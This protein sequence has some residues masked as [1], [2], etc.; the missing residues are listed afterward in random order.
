MMTSIF[1][2][3]CWLLRVLSRTNR[4]PRRSPDDV[5]ALLARLDR[6]LDDLERQLAAARKGD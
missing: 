3:A 5:Q 4:V 2:A 6:R 1:R